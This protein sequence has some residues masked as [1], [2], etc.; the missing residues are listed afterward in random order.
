[1]RGIIS[2]NFALDDVTAPPASLFS[3]AALMYK[4]QMDM[5]SK[6]RV[7]YI[8][9]LFPDGVPKL[10]CPSLAHFT[11]E[12]AI[13][14]HRIE[15]HLR[16]ISPWVGG[17]LVPGT[18]GEGW[19]LSDDEAMKI[20]EITLRA[21]TELRLWVLV[22][23]LKPTAEEMI[24]F[25]ERALD[26]IGIV[27]AGEAGQP[28]AS[29]PEASRE[30][31][32]DLR[33]HRIAGFTFCAPRGALL[34]QEAIADGLR[35]VLDLRLPSALYQLPQV[36]GNEIAPET[37]QELCHTYENLFLFKDS[38]G[39]D[40]ILSSGLDFGG[41][42]FARGAEGDYLEWFTR[43]KGS[44]DGF[45]L[46][47]AN[48]FP[49][50]L[51]EVVAEGTPPDRSRQ[52]SRLISA[53][54]NEAFNAV[55][56]VGSGNLFTNANKAIDHFNAWGPAAL[57]LAGPRLHDGTVISQEVIAQVGKILRRHDLTPVDGYLDEGRS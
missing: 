30:L 21:A 17:L 41:S 33:T 56:P 32:R 39:S 35:K 50:H 12:G 38:S 40:R 11:A 52:S 14:S 22:G 37:A 8:H 9:E 18:T 23:V 53:V 3:E 42:F 6:K 10:W 57:G 15:R 2:E 54:I 31:I 44:Y 1:M 4:R 24:A 49:R 51:S 25:V 48:C 13:D 28:G 55:R 45:L 36:T 19:E 26:R 20:L 29:S 7:E 47:T 46:S 5:K 16:F 43:A 34:S 27:R